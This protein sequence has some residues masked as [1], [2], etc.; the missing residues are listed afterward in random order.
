[1]YFRQ[2]CGVA[3]LLQ[4]NKLQYNEPSLVRVEDIHPISRSSYPYIFCDT[5]E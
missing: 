2:Q 3:V 5:Y 4:L 1:M